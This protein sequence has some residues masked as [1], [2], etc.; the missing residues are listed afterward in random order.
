M[1]LI[2]P[3]Y[4]RPD[5]SL[6]QTFEHVPIETPLILAVRSEERD[7][8]ENMISR[9]KRVND[10]IWEIPEGAVDGIA[11]TR[12]WI[13]KRSIEFRYKKIVMVDDDLHFIQRGLMP[14]KTDE[15]HL[16]PCPPSGFRDL[17][18]WLSNTLDKYAHCG[19]SMREGNVF[20]PGL[21]RDEETIRAIRMVGYRTDIVCKE[22][23]FF[24]KEVEGREDFDMTLQLIKKGYPNLVTYHWAQGQKTANAPGGLHGMRSDSQMEATAQILANFHKGIVKTVKKVNKTGGMSGERVDVMVYWKRALNMSGK[25]IYLS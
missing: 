17:L 4:R 9:M 19:V 6:A 11:T 3:T 1:K 24:R 12:D 20:L 25:K 21:H 22:Q 23:V 14:D 5:P 8:Y 2:V 10:T 7:Q 16:R 18:S 13:M 15:T